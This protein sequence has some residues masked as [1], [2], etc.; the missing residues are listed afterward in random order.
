MAILGYLLLVSVLGYQPFLFLERSLEEVIHC[1]LEVGRRYHIHCQTF[2]PSPIV[3]VVI[4]LRWWGAVVGPE[5]GGGLVYTSMLATGDRL[6]DASQSYLTP[7]NG[8]M[9]VLGDRGWMLT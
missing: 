7:Q 1:R 3:L 5:A 9:V 8:W 6:L 2:P 4:A